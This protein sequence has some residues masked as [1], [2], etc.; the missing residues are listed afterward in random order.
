MELNNSYIKIAAIAG[1]IT[2]VMTVLVLIHYHQISAR[3]GTI[4]IP[5]GNTYLGP[6]APDQNSQTTPNA[7]TNIFTTSSDV[8]W[9]TIKGNVYPY[10]ISVP[11]TLTLVAPKDS[12][13]YDIYAV[14]LPGYDVNST[15]L[16]GVDNLSNNPNTKQFINQPKLNYVNAWWHQFGGLKSVASIDQ[17]TNTSGMKG[18]KAKYVNAAGETPNLDVF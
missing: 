5:A 10:T 15:V 14:S 9:H 8:P 12:N 3:G 18:Y 2:L 11:T 6:N 17:F 1:G 7:P 4:V 13:I 16:I